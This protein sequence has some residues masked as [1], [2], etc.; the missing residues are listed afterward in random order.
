MMM[1]RKFH[2]LRRLSGAVLLALVIG[3]P[4]LRIK[5]ES[6]LRFD[7]PSLRLLF[8]GAEVRM[9]DFFIVLIALIFLTF[10]TLFIT[11][12]LG[13]VWCGWLCPQTVLVDATMF[14]EKARKRGSMALLAAYAAAAAVSSV[15]AVSLIGYFVSPY[16]MPALLRTGGTTANIAAGSAIVLAVLFFLDLIALRRSFCAGACPYAKLQSVLFDDRTLLVAFDPQRAEECRQCE[17]CVKACPMGIDIRKGPQMACIHCA[18]CVDACEGRMAVRNRQTL[19]DYTFGL[20][21]ERNKGLRVNPL[22][23]G[24]I[25]AVSLLFLVYLSLSRPPFDMNLRLQYTGTPEMRD[26]GSVVN[27]YELS[28]R[29]LEG[30]DQELSLAA[31]TPSGPVS[32]IPDAV[33]LMSERDV[34]RVPIAVA[35][36]NAREAGPGPVRVSIT[37]RSKQADKSVEKTVQFMMPKKK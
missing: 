28:L 7:I 3:L 2:R 11:T 8:F 26:D 6:A 19:I 21:G 16:D 30:T 25:T 9:A 37:V 1:S 18:E 13:R 22:I 29:N 36:S 15:I 4:F 27:T 12:V 31:T 32:L 20:P 24:A 35:L 17:A 5:G 33:L 23:T 10:F 34:T 14:V